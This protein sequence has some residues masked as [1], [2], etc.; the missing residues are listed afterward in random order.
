MRVRLERLDGRTIFVEVESLSPVLDLAP[1]F[2]GQPD[3]KGPFTPRDTARFLLVDSDQCVYRES[4][5]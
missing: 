4:R 3:A 2:L 1:T 5:A